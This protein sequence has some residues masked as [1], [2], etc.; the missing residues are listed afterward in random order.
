[1]KYKSFYIK[2]YKGIKELTL[3]LN[4]DPK[5]SIITLVGL[6]ESGKTTILEAI[7]IFSNEP[8]PEDIHKLIPKN[9]KYNFTD[10]IEIHATL[11]LTEQDEYDVRRICNLQGLTNTKAINEFTQKIIYEFKNS[12]YFIEES[13]W[14][15]EFN[16][17]GKKQKQKT[18]REYKDKSKEFEAVKE[19]ID[20]N[21]IPSII[22]Y[23]N[24]LFDFPSKIYLEKSE[25]EHKEQKT[26]R[27]V[28]NDIL[29]TLNEG[30]N[31]Q[32]HIINRLKMPTPGSEEALESTME[33]ISS[34][35][36]RIVFDAWGQLFNSSGKEIRL[37]PFIDPGNSLVYLEVKLKEGAD[38]FQISERS[39]GFKW[40]FTFLLFTE[41]RKNRLNE[42]GEMLFLLDEPASN[43][44]ST[45]QKNLL[46][47]FE[48]LVDKCKMIYTTH[49]HHLI[50]PKWLSGAYIVRNKA[51]NYETGA[52]DSTEEKTDIEAIIYKQFV[53]AHPNQRTYFQPILDSLEYNPSSLEEVPDIVLTEGKFDYYI[54]KY[55]NELVLNNEFGEINFYP[56]NSADRNSQ[57]IALY[58]AWGRDFIILLDGDKAGEDA[59]KR[60]NKEFGV[61]VD[62]KIITLKD[63]DSTFN[64]AIEGLFTPDEMLN[65][66]KFYDS[67]AASYDKSKFN[68]G[69]QNLYIQEEPF[70]FSEETK[71]KFKKILKIISR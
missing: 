62:N 56:G 13:G 22:Y 24:F 65:I 52:F 26:Y 41:F 5:T 59:K 32:D 6:N 10:T 9:R 47:T 69:I 2:N 1:M 12:E 20:E 53:S 4:K 60:Y 18:Y 25:T 19:F 16:L 40:F 68:T 17:I 71:D 49:S 55:M 3:D 7:S 39:L 44:H 43:L 15:F 54:L 28:L 48:K 8:K 63:I 64:C 38:Q 46:T 57:T 23:P 35:I 42:K 21:L 61:I 33:R 45:A 58:T 11:D 14:E 67:N 27:A 31:V 36:T 37:K 70:I 51:I 66:T 50:N 34:Q 30:V 29:D